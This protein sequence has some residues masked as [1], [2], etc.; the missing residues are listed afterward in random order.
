MNLDDDKLDTLL[1]GHMKR[2][3]EPMIGAAAPAFTKFALTHP[4]APAIEPTAPLWARPSVW[5][6]CAATLAAGVLLAI[7]WS[8]LTETP[9]VEDSPALLAQTTPDAPVTTVQWWESFDGGTV[10]LDNHTPARVIRRVQFEETRKTLPDGTIST[11]LGT[12][13][14]DV[15]LVD[16]PTQ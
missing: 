1:R 11:Q 13:Q 5:V 16:F 8:Y 9:P 7:G 10:M 14:Q 3:L 12:P 15:I 4:A 6:T 2:K